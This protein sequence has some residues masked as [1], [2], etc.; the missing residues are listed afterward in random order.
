MGVGLPKE[1]LSHRRVAEGD[2]LTLTETPDGLRLTPASKE[3]A[4]SMAVF[5]SLNRRYR[6]ALKELAK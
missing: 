1:A 2:T 6:N 4:L 5:A 3:F